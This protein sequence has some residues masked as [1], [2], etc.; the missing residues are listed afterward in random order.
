MIVA[1]AT[2]GGL[3]GQY[4]VVLKASADTDAVTHVHAHK[5]GAD[6]FARYRYA[7][8]GYAAN[9]SKHALHL[10]RSD[11]RVAYVSPNTRVRA[12]AQALPTGINRIDGELSSTRSG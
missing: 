3:R 10:V 12:A 1:P 4:V 6:V 9:L 5:Y 8:K 7:R 11:P 2:A